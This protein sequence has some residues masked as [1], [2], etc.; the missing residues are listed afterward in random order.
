MFHGLQTC[1]VDGKF[2]NFYK[3][4]LYVR[5]ILAHYYLKLIGVMFDIYDQNIILTIIV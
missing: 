1:C 5:R 3:P 2:Q 4:Q